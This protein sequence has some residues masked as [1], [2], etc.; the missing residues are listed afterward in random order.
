MPPRIC[1]LGA[2]DPIYP[3]N[4]ILRRGL[5]A[6]GA[7]VIECRVDTSLDSR[8]RAAALKQNFAAVAG[9]CDVILLA[10]FNQVNISTALS[11]ARRYH[12][13]LV[14]DAFTPVFDS[15]VNDRG[16]VK[17][18]SP[19]GVRYRHLD[20]AAV[21]KPDLILT[22]TQQHA[23][24]F[25]QEFGANRK[26]M[27]V[28]PVG[29]SRE[30]FEEPYVTRTEPGLK[31]LFFGTYIPLHG[32]EVILQAANLLRMQGR[33]RFELIGRGQMYNEMR[34]LA[35]LLDL[36]Y[37]TLS[38]PVLFAELPRRVASADICLG[39]FGTTDKTQ[40]VIPNKVYQQLAM[41]RPVITADTPAI[42][43][44]FTPGEHLLVVKPG[45][46]EALATSISHLANDLPR[47]AMLS[48]AGHKLM[49][50]S[51]TEAAVGRRLL[52][53]IERIF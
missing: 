40:R 9:K 39:I 8:Q 47:R 21:N 7:E 42:R 16:Q 19:R 13:K 3:R 12:K 11:L 45:D 35:R 31:I 20:R 43:E 14:V 23:N 10:E 17:P 46:P 1:Y 36:P 38:D 22:D 48:E 2:Y 32:V 30:W 26:R 25:A 49:L 51:F 6:N 5:E 15:A 29:A 4:L 34:E 41:G 37:V 50:Q 53:A 18:L 44:E 27:A 52:D 28:I 33:L 24:Y